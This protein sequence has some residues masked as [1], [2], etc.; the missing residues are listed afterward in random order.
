[1]N[2]SDID[3]W[4]VRVPGSDHMHLVETVVERDGHTEARPDHAISGVSKPRMTY[5]PAP[6]PNGTAVLIAPGGGYQRLVLD[7]EGIE[8][9]RWLN[10]LGIAA[11]VLTY[12][13]PGEG[14]LPPTKA[15]LQDA[16]RAMRIIRA[17]SQKFGIDP[18]KV[19]AMGFSAGG[20]V[21]A[22][23]ATHFEERS[24]D[25]M[26]DIN[27]QS[28]RPDFLILGYPVICMQEKHAHEGSRRALLGEHPTEAQMLSASCEY[29]VKVDTPPTFLFLAGDDAS[30]PA[31]NSVR[32]YLALHR[33]RVPAQMHIYAKGGHGFG[34]R[35]SPEEPA[36]H[37][38]G[39]CERWMRDGGWL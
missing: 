9:A 4:T 8:P 28:A 27:E 23:L 17:R 39:E 3:L 29:S 16:Q 13:L 19:G 1:M 11:F 2:T 12:R 18:T 15:P 24:Y 21:V 38:V 26:D 22:T 36:S 7:K 33:H 34:M 20:H 5:F 30:V 37:W 32:F 35:L 14:H 6:N 10:S 25:S 31:E